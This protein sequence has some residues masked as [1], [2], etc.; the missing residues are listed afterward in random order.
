MLHLRNANACTTG[1][2]KPAGP[3]KTSRKPNRA[4]GRRDT[5]AAFWALAIP[6]RE[7]NSCALE[8]GLWKGGV[9]NQ[10]DTAPNAEDTPG[11]QLMALE[12]I[13]TR[14]GTERRAPAKGCCD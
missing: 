8:S 1:H 6:A 11:R 9:Q 5:D 7:R 14:V 13:E 4:N 10:D 12:G 2:G 3:H